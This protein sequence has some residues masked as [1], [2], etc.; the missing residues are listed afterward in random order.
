MKRGIPLSWFTGSMRTRQGEHS[1]GEVEHKLARLMMWAFIKIK[2]RFAAGL[3][4]NP[5]GSTGV[6][7]INTAC[8]LDLQVCNT[9]HR[10]TKQATS[11]PWLQIVLFLW[12]VCVCQCMCGTHWHVLREKRWPGTGQCVQCR[13]NAVPLPQPF[14]CPASAIRNVAS[15]TN[16]RSGA[17]EAGDLTVGLWQHTS[18]AITF[19]SISCL[20]ML[21]RNR[22]GKLIKEHTS[23]VWMETQLST[24]HVF[25]VS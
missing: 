18:Y 12:F 1:D 19:I 17:V 24:I 22:M 4:R 6:V 8:I 21:L 14:P 5:G 2:C 23:L 16:S 20:A 11:F 25:N 9:G 10:T 3:F 15:I 13:Q 7:K